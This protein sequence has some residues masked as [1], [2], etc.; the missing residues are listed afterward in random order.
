MSENNNKPLPKMEKQSE[1]ELERVSGGRL[2][3][4]GNA[5]DIYYAIG[6]IYN[7]YLLVE[8][9]KYPCPRCGSWNVGN[10]DP[11]TIWQMRVFYKDCRFFGCRDG[12]ADELWGELIEKKLKDR[13]IL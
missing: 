11:G 4:S 9:P 13:N 12:Y 10:Y 3:L 5:D 6:D 2:L 8:P 1:D 7:D